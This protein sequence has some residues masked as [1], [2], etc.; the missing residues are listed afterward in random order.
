MGHYVDAPARTPTIIDWVQSTFCGNG[1]GG[2]IAKGHTGVRHEQI[3]RP[4]V[5]FNFINKCRH[6]DFV[7]NINSERN[8]TDL[9]GNIPCRL[10]VEI[11]DN[12]FVFIGGE[13]PTECATDSVTAACNNG[14]AHNLSL[15]P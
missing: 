6:G 11:H 3:D 12:N 4:D 14:N 2:T 15:M 10:L 5:P 13:S 7:T 8:S 1:T 9:T